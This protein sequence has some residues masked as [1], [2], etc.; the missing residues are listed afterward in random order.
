MISM[1]EKQTSFRSPAPHIFAECKS[2]LLRIEIQA[3]GVGVSQYIPRRIFSNKNQLVG[4]N[5]WGPEHPS[6]LGS[7]QPTIPEK[8]ASVNEARDY[9]ASSRLTFFLYALG[10]NSENTPNKYSDTLRRWSTAF[11]RFLTGKENNLTAREKSA[12]HVLKIQRLILRGFVST[13][14]NREDVQPGNQT[15]WD[16]N[17]PIFEE[18]VSLADDVLLDAPDTASSSI[19]SFTLDIGLVGSLYDVARRCRDP[20][21]RRRAIHLLHSF[22]RQEGLWD[23]RLAARVAKR[24]VDIEESGLG[25]VVSCN[26]IPNSARVA[27]VLPVF[28]P[29][30]RSV[31]SRFIK[32]A[33]RQAPQID[34]HEIY[35]Y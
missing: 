25:T 1:I 18:I 28:E 8:F 13:G 7:Y 35:E 26:D 14:C 23:G 22:S 32:G 24:V 4:S 10:A 6:H 5:A 30:K 21:I 33:K 16:K 12:V 2:R 20:N 29:E 9:L 11:D 27:A 3:I 15:L 19:S 34:I 31:T 17:D